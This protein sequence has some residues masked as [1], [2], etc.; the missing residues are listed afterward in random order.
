VAG[1]AVV[2][3]GSRGIGAAVVGRLA[4]AGWTVCFSYRTDRTAAEAVAEAFGATP[5]AADVA[6]PD[7]VAALFAAADRLGPVGV[8]VNNAGIVGARAR[9]DELDAARLARMFAV[10]V[11]G[12]F[13]CAGAAVRRMSTERGGAGGVI[14]NISSVG[15]R[16]G[17]PGEYVDYA[18]SKGAVDTFTVGLAREVAAEGI[19]VNAV[20]PGII[21]TEIHASGGQPDRVERLGPAIPIGRAGTVDEVADA[22]AWLCSPGATYVTGALLDVSGGR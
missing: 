17:S 5:I 22:V 4:G 3:G 13:L 12:S 20:R 14:V 15:A 1:V 9:V 16:L 19:R 11:T 18:A 7:D 2:T 6:E 21:D 8:L 10:N